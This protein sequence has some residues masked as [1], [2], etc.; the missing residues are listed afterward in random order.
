LDEVAEIP[1]ERSAVF[2]P[3]SVVRRC[4][5]HRTARQPP[6]GPARRVVQARRPVRELQPNDVDNA[7]GLELLG[8]LADRSGIVPREPRQALLPREAIVSAP[9]PMRRNRLQARPRASLE[10]AEHRHVIA[11]ESNATA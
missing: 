3:T 6:E 10:V 7:A 4:T 2:P 1:S 5:E 11:H 9:L 8:E